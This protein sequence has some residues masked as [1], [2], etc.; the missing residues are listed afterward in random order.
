MQ[1]DNSRCLPSPKRHPPGSFCLAAR[2]PS[3]A[4]RAAHQE[5]AGRKDAGHLQQQLRLWACV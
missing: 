5:L 1:Y 4:G 2:P 3:R